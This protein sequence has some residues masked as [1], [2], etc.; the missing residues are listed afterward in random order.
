[1]E[2]LVLTHE[3]AAVFFEKTLLLC[4]VVQQGCPTT[5]VL[6]TVSHVQERGTA[7]ALNFGGENCMEVARTSVS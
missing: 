1:M 7:S 3:H 5:V 2:M 4:K 6:E